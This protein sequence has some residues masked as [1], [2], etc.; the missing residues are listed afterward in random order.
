[1]WSDPLVLRQLLILSGDDILDS[2]LEE[3]LFA[4]ET[5]NPSESAVGPPETLVE[6]QEHQYCLTAPNPYSRA[7]QTPRTDQE[8]RSGVD[9][10]FGVYNQIARCVPPPTT[11]F[12][13]DR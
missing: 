2:T 7:V 6:L 5:S 13:H 8:R 4:C 9:P 12:S 10:S 11:W 1:M 3:L